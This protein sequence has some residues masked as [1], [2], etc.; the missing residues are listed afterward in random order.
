MIGFGA[1]MGF[2]PEPIDERWIRGVVALLFVMFWFWLA[3]RVYEFS[4]VTIGELGIGQTRILRPRGMAVSVFL[5]WEDIE[6]IRCKGNDVYLCGTNE[7]IRV[8]FEIFS[9][10]QDA[11]RFV[12]A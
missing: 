8:N 11:A 7:F 1:W 2:K 9:D 10:P 5:L 12:D 6:S 4:T 3:R